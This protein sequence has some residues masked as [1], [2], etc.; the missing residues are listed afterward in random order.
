VTL[1]LQK[2]SLSQLKDTHLSLHHDFDHVV[3]DVVFQL[4]VLVLG[5]ELVG[6]SREGIC[7]PLMEPIN[8]TA[9]DQAGE[10]AQSISEC[11]A[12][13]RHGDDDVQVL[14][15]LIHVPGED[16][17]RPVLASSVRSLAATLRDLELVLTGIEIGHLAGVQDGAHLLQ[18][19]FFG[20]LCI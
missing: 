5:Q 19:G 6:H 18:E 2:E 12:N 9:I 8:G 16:F 15:A 7:R 1:Q 3:S 14:A 20:N 4:N 13:W 10:T 17:R 11:C